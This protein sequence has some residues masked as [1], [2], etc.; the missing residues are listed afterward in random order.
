MERRSNMRRTRIF[1]DDNTV[2]LL[3]LITLIVF[4]SM[5]FLKSVIF[6]HNKVL[7]AQTAQTDIQVCAD[8][9]DVT[10]E[11]VNVEQI[12]MRVLTPEENIDSIII[13][14]CSMYGIEPELVKS[15]VYYESRYN[16]TA[17]NGN[18]IGLMQVSKQWHSKRAKQL[19][20]YNLYDPYGNILVGVDY[21]KELFDRYKDPKLVLMMYN[22]KQS[23]ALRLYNT[24]QISSYARDVLLRT[25]SLK[26]GEI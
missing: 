9:E 21:L 12:S 18:Y 5:L 15:I 24:N 17:K 4:V 13:E 25:E 7:K 10:V 16:K 26:Q 6:N 20:V 14:I 11:L 8:K 1:I 19:G 23:T 22:M 3:A 2:T